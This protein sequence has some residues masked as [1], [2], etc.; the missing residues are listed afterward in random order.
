MT[1]CFSIAS[2]TLEYALPCASRIDSLA[3]FFTL[4]CEATLINIA[5]F[6]Y[7]Y[8]SRNL[9]QYEMSLTPEGD[10]LMMEEIKTIIKLK[11]LKIID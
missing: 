1:G 4:Y 2:D 8:H 10:L 6:I 7:P 5:C 11:D 9:L 3:S